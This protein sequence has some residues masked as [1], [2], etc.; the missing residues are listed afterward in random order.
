[1]PMTPE[2][3]TSEMQLEAEL[4]E[5]IL[6]YRDKDGYAVSWSAGGSWNH[7]TP[8][9]ALRV[10]ADALDEEYEELPLGEEASLIDPWEEL[11]RESGECENKDSGDL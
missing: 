11:A 2:R 10:V 7:P 6:V 1:M 8:G 9:S 4:L 5:E 3:E